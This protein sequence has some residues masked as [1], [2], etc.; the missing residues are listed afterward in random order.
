MNQSQPHQATY[1]T[2]QRRTILAGVATMLL[3]TGGL[4]WFSSY[5]AASAQTN[6]PI[7]LTLVSYAVTRS[8]YEK[9]IPKFVAEYKKQTGQTVQFQ[10]SYGGSGSQT[11]A[12]ID[13]LDA[14]VVHLAIPED[15][16][17]LQNRGLI[18][19][20]WT[21][22]TP[23][24]AIVQR[25]VIAF[26]T[27]PGNPK[28]IKAWSDLT[29]PGIKVITANPKTSG[30]ARWNFLGLWSSVLLTGGN[31]TKAR[32]FVS[33][34]YKNTP[35]LPKDA[36]EA[37][38]VFVKQ[39]QGDVLLNYENEVLLARSKG[40]NIAFTIPQVNFSIDTPV[41]VVDQYVDRKGT[42]KAAEAFVKYLFTPAAQEEYAKAFF[43]PVDPGVSRKFANQFPT[44]AK[45]GTAEKLG[46]W[47]NIQKKFFAN[48]AVFDQIVASN[49]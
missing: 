6:K 39:G 41:A 25:S 10:Q 18:K 35:I 32:Q 31:D 12:V 8:A 44:I 48:N 16:D 13:G 21:G 5:N 15:V 26:I 29:K 14:D 49:R 4:A 20:G 34:V 9:I 27:R 19:P 47:A 3:T 42:R 40:E 11:R 23:N 2:W 46:G 33:Q 38:D 28:N 43:R 17:Q 30:G 36:R 1:P 22:R 7:K 37:T 45:L 24:K